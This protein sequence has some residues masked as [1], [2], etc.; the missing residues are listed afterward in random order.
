VRCGFH[1]DGHAAVTKEPNDREQL[2]ARI[3]ELESALREIAEHPHQSYE[4]SSVDVADGHRCAGNIARAA[5]NGTNPQP[6]PENVS[7][8]VVDSK[9]ADCDDDN[10][11]LA[12]LDAVLEEV[13]ER[14]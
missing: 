14:R 3:S 7:Q 4:V 2:L 12:D 13:A 10:E 5:L 1:R 11:I 9:N 6:I 8:G